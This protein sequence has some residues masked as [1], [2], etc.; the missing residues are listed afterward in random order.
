MGLKRAVDE[1]GEGGGVTEDRVWTGNR[2]GLEVIGKEGMEE[3]MKGWSCGIS[4]SLVTR[5]VGGGITDSER[6][7]RESVM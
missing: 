7:S 4:N 3:K 1:G 2:G 5:V 6:G